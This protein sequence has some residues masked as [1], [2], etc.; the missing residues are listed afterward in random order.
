M[1]SYGTGD[2]DTVSNASIGNG[3]VTT[4]SNWK[5][6]P[7]C[8][9]IDSSTSLLAQHFCIASDDLHIDRS[10]SMLSRI[11]NMPKCGKWK[12]LGYDQTERKVIWDCARS[13]QVVH[14]PSHSQFPNI[15]ARKNG[16]VYDIRVRRDNDL[17]TGQCHPTS[18]LQPVQYGITET[19]ENLI[20][21]KSQRGC[22]A[23]T[24]SERDHR[25]VNH[26]QIPSRLGPMAS[27]RQRSERSSSK[28][29]ACS[30]LWLK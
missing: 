26:C 16:G 9:D 8:I 28:H 3:I 23:V 6:Q 12:P 14:G 4:W 17:D 21:Y 15:S 20:T 2:N 18:V 5:A 7:C 30:F 13:K 24:V 25:M 22:S 10:R 27:L 11:E 29:P 19:C 1:I